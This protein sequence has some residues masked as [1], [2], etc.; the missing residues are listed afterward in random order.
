MR[1]HLT[2]KGQVTISKAMRD[3]LCLVP[4]AALRFATTEGGGVVDCIR[5]RLLF[6]NTRCDGKRRCESV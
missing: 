4:I 3:Y 5:N 2:V 6:P 1:A